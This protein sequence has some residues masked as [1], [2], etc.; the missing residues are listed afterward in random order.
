MLLEAILAPLGVLDEDHSRSGR[1][2][3][4]HGQCCGQNQV[5][6]VALSP[7]LV[8]HLAVWEWGTA[9]GRSPLA[10]EAPTLYER[11]R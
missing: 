1:P 9:K 2:G 6:V 11:S 10:M 5:V 4:P 3:C 7:R 8:E